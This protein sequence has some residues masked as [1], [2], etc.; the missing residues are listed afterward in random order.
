MRWF[1]NVIRPSEWLPLR[2]EAPSFATRERWVEISARNQDVG[3]T[4]ETFIV[5]ARVETDVMPTREKI[6]IMPSSEVAASAILFIL[7][8]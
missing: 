4:E 8:T 6:I 3:T 1:E 2:S 5:C 7:L